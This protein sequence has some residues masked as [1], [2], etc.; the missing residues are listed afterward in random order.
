MPLPLSPAKTDP[1]S[2]SALRA[3]FKQLPIS[4]DMSFEQAMAD[5]A[6]AIGIRNVAAASARKM[7]ATNG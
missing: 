7:G 1:T 2:E 4:R 3:A 5:A 6:I